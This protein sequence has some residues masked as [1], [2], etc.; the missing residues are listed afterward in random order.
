MSSP[1]MRGW[2][3]VS[4]KHVHTILFLHRRTPMLCYA[5]FVPHPMRF[6]RGTADSI[7]TR[8]RDGFAVGNVGGARRR[9]RGLRCIRVFAN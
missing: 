3:N 1:C 6:G 9:I 7:G 8:I 4:K 5:N 2:S